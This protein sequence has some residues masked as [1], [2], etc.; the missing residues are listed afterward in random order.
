MV[1]VT[2]GYWE[3]VADNVVETMEIPQSN[4]TLVIT[5]L[6]VPSDIKLS[7]LVR[8]FNDNKGQE[9]IVAQKD[10]ITMRYT[11]FS[12]S[13]A[14]TYYSGESGKKITISFSVKE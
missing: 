12:L 1:K 11:N 13:R 6:N 7:D 2:S 9:L 8:D 3:I 10:E 14:M 4:H 5:L